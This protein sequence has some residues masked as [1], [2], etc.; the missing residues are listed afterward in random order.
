[1]RFFVRLGWRRREHLLYIGECLTGV[2]ERLE[3]PTEVEV[4]ALEQTE[5]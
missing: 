3:E 1:M 5:I 2:E 4:A